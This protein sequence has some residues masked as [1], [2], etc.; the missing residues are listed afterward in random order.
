MI[1]ARPLTMALLR[2]LAQSQGIGISGP[3]VTRNREIGRALQFAVGRS[4][5]IPENFRRFPTAARSRYS[6]VVPDGLLLAGCLH[7]LG[8]VSF[9]PQGAFLEVINPDFLE[10]KGRN[11]P[12][13]LSTAHGQ[14][15]GLID[16]LSLIRKPSSSIFGARQPRPALLLVTTEDTKVDRELVWEAAKRNVALFQSFVLEKDGWLMVGPFNQLT[17]FADV[18]P[19]FEL[20]S[21]PE[22]L[23][24]ERK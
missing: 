13:T 3:E 21:E 1:G 5:D 12:I 6:S 14:L 22:Q 4:L 18:P 19:Q 10:V 16:A 23:V 7:L 24:P 17:R 20:A 15:L 11:G 2:Q 9:N 8:G